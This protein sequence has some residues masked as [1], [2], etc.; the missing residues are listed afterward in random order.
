M[1]RIQVMAFRPI[2]EAKLREL[3]HKISLHEIK[4][5]SDAAKEF[6]KLL[7]GETGGDLLRLYFYRSPECWQLRHGG[8]QG[9]SCIFPL[10]K[11][12]LSPSLGKK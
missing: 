8:K 12:I 1:D 2:L 6:S 11:T 4:L 10:I 9:L 7:K 5:C 3:L